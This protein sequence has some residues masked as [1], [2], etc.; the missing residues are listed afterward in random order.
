[1]PNVF[2]LTN[3]ITLVSM[4]FTILTLILLFMKRISKRLSSKVFLSLI[5]V[6]GNIR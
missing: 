3:A 5:L 4:L 1:M 2:F 6:M